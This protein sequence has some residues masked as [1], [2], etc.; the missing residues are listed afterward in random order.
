MPISEVRFFVRLALEYLISVV[1]YTIF[2]SV[3][4]A[5]GAVLHWTVV[6]SLK[7]SGALPVNARPHNI[8]DT[9]CFSRGLGKI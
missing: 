2:K 4:A 7:A 8:L 5:P 3:N 1:G 9:S 6:R